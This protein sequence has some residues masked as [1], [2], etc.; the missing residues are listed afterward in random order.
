[1]SIRRADINE[2][3]HESRICLNRWHCDER[4]KRTASCTEIRDLRD[5]SPRETAN[6]IGET[7]E[8]I[9]ITGSRFYE[10]ATFRS[11]F[12][13]GINI[14][15]LDADLR[16]NLLPTKFSSKIL[17]SNFKGLQIGNR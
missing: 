17:N 2:V 16:N 1:M 5:G 11:T 14:P 6:D 15:V 13:R 9:I 10:R 8:G 4:R 7:T 3:N 12:L